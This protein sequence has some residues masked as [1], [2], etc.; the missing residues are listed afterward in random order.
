M[1]WEPVRSILSGKILFEY[2][3]ERRLVRYRHKRGTEEVIDLAR[4]HGAEDLAETVAA[5]LEEG[6]QA[7]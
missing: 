5:A 6:E 7:G 3:A 2:D 4:F 1:A